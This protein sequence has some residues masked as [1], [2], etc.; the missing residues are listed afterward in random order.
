MLKLEVSDVEK[1][2]LIKTK[3]KPSHIHYTTISIA[4]VL[5]MRR[6]LNIQ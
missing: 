3:C 5:P 1:V 4:Q 6:E 2:K